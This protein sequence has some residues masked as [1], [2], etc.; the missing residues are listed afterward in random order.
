M[1]TTIQFEFT[2]DD[3]RIIVYDKL[4]YYS[5]FRYDGASNYKIYHLEN[6]HYK[7]TE[8]VARGTLEGGWYLT[9]SDY[10]EV[11]STGENAYQR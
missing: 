10:S 11:A 1:K 7:P 8:K 9:L 2:S 4:G 6:D 3:S 5:N